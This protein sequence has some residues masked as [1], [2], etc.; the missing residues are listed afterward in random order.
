MIGRY[1]VRVWLA[2]LVLSAGLLLLVGCSLPAGGGEQARAAST[3][4]GQAAGSQAT[5]T[6][7]PEL[8]S[9]TMPKPAGTSTPIPM[10][11][12][13]PLRAAL[14]TPFVVTNTPTPSDLFAAATLMVNQTRQV[15]ET[16]TTTP[17]PPNMVTATPTLTPR[18]VTNT[19]RPGNRATA[20]HMALEATARAMTSG[21][22]DPNQAVITATPTETPRPTNTPRPTF[23]P[24]PTNAPR[25]TNT[26]RPTRTPTPTPSVTPV[27]VYLEELPTSPPPMPTPVFPRLLVGRILFLSTMSGERPNRPGVYVVNADG[28]QL[29]RL[30]DN[31]PYDRAEAREA[32]SAD[33]R[34]HAYVSGAVSWRSHIFYYD[35]FYDA[36]VQTT[37]LGSGKAWSPVWSP[38]SHWIAFVANQTGN[39]EIW[40]VEKDNPPAVQLTSNSWEWDHH[41]SWSPDGNQIVFSSNRGG[42]RQIWIMDADGGNQHPITDP[43]YEAWN[44]V[45]VKYPD[46]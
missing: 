13:T 5:Q 15:Q 26:P 43:S 32:F 38:A 44:P 46:S 4:T 11:T 14:W 7:E 28:S 40:I 39:D 42:G 9:P 2:V 36:E 34:Y 25:P 18:V 12:R 8:A 17:A 31:W 6:A 33:G 1:K 3:D 10:P 22:P 19:P 21:T 30:T 45:W 37:F 20:D 41:P 27:M 35:D 16:G 29:A 24:R 23:T